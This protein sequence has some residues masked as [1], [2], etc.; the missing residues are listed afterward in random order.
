VQKYKRDGLVVLGFPC[1]DFGEQEPGPTI[2]RSSH[3]ARTVMELASHVE[4]TSRERAGA[5]SCMRRYAK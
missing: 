1:N 3:S 4:Q 2:R 5:A